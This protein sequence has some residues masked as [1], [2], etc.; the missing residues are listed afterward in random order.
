MKEFTP[1]YKFIAEAD[2]D[3][4]QAAELS[5][6]DVIGNWDEM[7]EISA[8]AFS[9]D[10][11]A[12]PKSV[13]RLNIHINSPG[14]SVYDAQGIYSRLADHRSQKIVYVDGL[15][16]SAASIIAMV[17]HKVYMRANANMMIHLPSGLTAGDKHEHEKTKRALQSIEDAMIN[18]YI[19][20]TGLARD[21][22]EQMLTDETW[23]N[24]EQ[25]V[26]KGFAD[27]VRGVI[28]TS[29]IANTKKAIFN[30]VTFDLSRFH[31][32]PAFNN[33]TTE[34]QTM[35]T[36]TTEPVNEVVTEITNGGQSDPGKPPPNPTP[37]PPKP[38]PQTI[39]AESDIEKGVKQE[40]ARIAALQKYDKPATHDI[41]VKAI[42]D[43]KTVSEITDDLFAA[44]EKS[45]HQ[46]AR[47]ADA[48]DLSL[49]R[50]SDTT[51]G[52][53]NNNGDDFA[54]LLVKAVKSQIKSRGKRVSQSL[55]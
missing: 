46:T 42:T 45:T 13:K 25:A 37:P 15:A 54:A 52:S 6:Y 24:A 11:A 7:G 1:F 50:G 10:L 5:I 34:E 55:S 33:A 28:K 47:R 44:L 40:R 32:V 49:I 48:A 43:G 16:A 19:K 35:P 14:G 30:G 27:E 18:T 17:G 8:R 51:P 3:D 12:L 31:N 29:A 23:L 4:P 53:E 26:D 38:P 22:I 41:I 2:D 20:K 39:A 36:E 9:K 21:E